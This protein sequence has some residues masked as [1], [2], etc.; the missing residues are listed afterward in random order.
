M[1]VNII[2][3]AIKEKAIKYTI[4]FKQYGSTWLSLLALWDFSSFILHKFVSFFLNL[5]VSGS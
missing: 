4:I 2:E 1:S 3:I 5:L